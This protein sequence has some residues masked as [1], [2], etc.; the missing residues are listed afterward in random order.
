MA[1]RV[2][3]RNMKRAIAWLCPMMLACGSRLSGSLAA[4]LRIFFRCA[5]AVSGPI[6]AAS[7]SVERTA[8]AATSVSGNRKDLR[9]SMGSP[10]FR[11]ELGYRGLQS[12]V[13]DSRGP[14]PQQGGSSASGRGVSGL[15]LSSENVTANC[16]MK[17]SPLP[18]PVELVTATRKA[19]APGMR[20]RGAR[21]GARRHGG[22]PCR[23]RKTRVSAAT[24]IA[25][26]RRAAGLRGT[27]A[28][29]HGALA[30]TGPQDEGGARTG[31]GG[32]LARVVEH[33]EPAVEQFPELDAHAGPAPAPRARRQLQPPQPQAHGVVL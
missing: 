33:D 2:R 11:N 31:L 4:I 27:R 8:I 3:P 12:G 30:A 15:S 6:S 28:P 1:K 24:P 17:M 19:L 5:S 29:G 20:P 21:G 9:L 18:G 13:K 16:S 7:A 14:S 10:F 22:R 32:D 26:P 23:A 25:P